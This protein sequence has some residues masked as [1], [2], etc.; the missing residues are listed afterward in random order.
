MIIAGTGTC[1]YPI[2]LS[3]ILSLRI[4]VCVS[5][6]G[7]GSCCGNQVNRR[8][9]LEPRRFCFDMWMCGC[10]FRRK[11]NLDSKK[12]TWFIIKLWKALLARWRWRETPKQWYYDYDTKM[13]P[14]SCSIGGFMKVCLYSSHCIPVTSSKSPGVH[15]RWWP[16]VF[17]DP[18]NHGEWSWPNI[19]SWNISY[20]IC[21]V[22]C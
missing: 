2:C 20:F 6:E 16:H 18:W 12:Y 19:G 9:S 21:L 13:G 17:C 1:I 7:H 15:Q 14:L 22:S 8:R 11:P 10:L 4:Y 5:A 3:S